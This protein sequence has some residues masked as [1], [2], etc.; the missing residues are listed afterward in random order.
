MA[1]PGGAR[2]PLRGSG[3]RLGVPYPP[4]GRCPGS[5]HPGS[6][7]LDGVEELLDD[8]SDGKEQEAIW[9]SQPVSKKP[10]LQAIE[11]KVSR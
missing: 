7:Y 6:G 4:G 1:L 5:P 3:Q 11:K 9:A 8:L 2:S 10:P